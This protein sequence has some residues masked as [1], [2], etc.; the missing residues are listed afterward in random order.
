MPDVF[1]K[2]KRSEVMALIRSHSNKATELRLVQL[3]REHGITGWRRQVKLRVDV[4]G[5]ASRARRKLRPSDSCSQLPTNPSQL[6]VRPDFVFRKQRVAVFVDGCFWHGCPRHG[7][8]PVQ[9]AAFWTAKFARNKARDRAVTRALRG[10]GWTVL[11][12]WECALK[13]KRAAATMRP[14]CCS[15]PMKYPHRPAH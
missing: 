5:G 12:V 3:L 4:S 6:S 2:T 11:R 9:N 10:A 15:A 7:T 13:V 1:S 14:K 8:K